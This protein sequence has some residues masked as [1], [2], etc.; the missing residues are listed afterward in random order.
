[1]CMPMAFPMQGKVNLFHLEIVRMISQSWLCIVLMQVTNIVRVWGESC[2][3][4]SN[5]GYL[6]DLH[7]IS[8]KNFFIENWPA[9]PE[10]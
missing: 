2:G 10:K 8:K 9:F 3:C 1:M 5:M 4:Q 7:Y 6:T